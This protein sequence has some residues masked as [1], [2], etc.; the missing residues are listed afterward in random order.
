MVRRLFTRER[1]GLGGVHIHH[2]LADGQAHRQQVVAIRAGFSSAWPSTV[3][4]ALVLRFTT[5]TLRRYFFDANVV[6]PRRTSFTTTRTVPVRGQPAL[7]S[8]AAPRP[9]VS[10]C[11]SSL[12]ETVSVSMGS[13]AQGEPAR[14]GEEDVWGSWHPRPCGRGS[15]EII[16]PIIVTRSAGSRRTSAT[17]PRPPGRRPLP[18]RGAAP[19]TSWSAAPQ[20]TVAR[21]VAHVHRPQAAAAG[22]LGEAEQPAV[23]LVV[24]AGPER[25]QFVEPPF[26]DLGV[27]D[28]VERTVQLHACRGAS[29]LPERIGRHRCLLYSRGRPPRPSV[30]FVFESSRSR[31]AGRASS[32]RTRWPAGAVL[33]PLHRQKCRFQTGEQLLLKRGVQSTADEAPLIQ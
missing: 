6:A 17:V 31:L 11:V 32:P 16:R 30:S 28:G 22:Q 23:P 15:P 29:A 19:S 21:L 33:L 26:H 14:Q 3:T 20:N 13:S 8:S 4:V 7:P 12:L 9:C 25:Q 24:V 2:R 10:C 18:P 1:F 5:R 27:N